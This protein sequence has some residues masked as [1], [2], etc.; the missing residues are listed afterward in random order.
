MVCSTRRH[1]CGLQLLCVLQ[2]KKKLL[3]KKRRALW[4][5]KWL[6]RRPQKGS[7][8]EIFLELQVENPEDLKNYTRI[9]VDAFYS[10]LVKTEP[11]ISKQNTSLIVSISPGACLEA[12][13]LYLASAVL[14]SRLHYSTRISKQ[15]LGVII[16]ETCEAIYNDIQSAPRLPTPTI[17]GRQMTLQNDLLRGSEKR[18]T[19]AYHNSSRGKSSRPSPSVLNHILGIV[20]GDT[21]EEKEGRPCLAVA[22][23]NRSLVSC[24]RNRWVATRFSIS[25]QS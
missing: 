12:T 10:L 23:A 1:Y 6:S 14:H 13:L 5:K 25:F 16:P 8:N 15:S 17:P 4:C 11:F 7:F 19:V 18:D 24:S 9:P 20:T 22:S 2:K 3:R 21:L